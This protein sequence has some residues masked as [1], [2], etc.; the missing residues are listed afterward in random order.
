M[1]CF[2]VGILQGQVMELEIL[3]EWKK[4]EASEKWAVQ[5]LDFI[6]SGLAL[7]R[8]DGTW[9]ESEN[10]AA[11]FSLEKKRLKAQADGVPN[12]RYTGVRFDVGLPVAVNEG[13]VNLLPP[14]HD[15][16][17]DVCG[18]HWGWQG[19]YVFLAIEGRWG[20]GGPKKGG[21]AYHLARTPNVV[22]VELP[23]EFQGGG[24][25][26]LQLG[27]NMAQILRGLDAVVHGTSTHSREGDELVPLLKA[28]IAEAFSLRSVRYDTYQPMTKLEKGR[29]LELIPGTTPYPVAI[30]KR[31]PQVEFP[32]D[33]PLTEEGVAL[34]EKLFHDTRL[35]INN[36]QSCASCHDR[37]FAFS[38]PR[39]LSLGAEGQAGK[40]H[41]M[42]LFNLAWEKVFFWDGRAGSLREQVLMPIQ[43][44]HEMNETLER[45]VDKIADLKG[46]FAVAFET[47][48]ITPERMAKSLEQYLLSL[49]SQESRF[50]KAAR[51][52][53]EMTEEEKQGLQLFV[54]EFDPARGLRGA[55]CFHCHGGT[56]F[57]DHQFKNNG[58]DLNP[59]DLGR[60]L[61]TG[62]PADKG[63]F[64]TPSL[65]NIAVTAP[66]M[67]DG[68]FASLEEVVE[69]YSQGVK[70][71]DTLDPNLA[72]HPETGLQL[73][74][75]EKRAL[76]AFLKTLT[77][78]EFISAPANNKL[79]HRP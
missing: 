45:A 37:S 36:R 75:A 57:T 2:Y 35:S 55:D 17:P 25:M 20:E 4:A 72:K 22:R 32:A 50:D 64:K 31:L 60:M 78:E 33:N 41:S 56:L 14:D 43:D 24:P 71:S 7:K 34:G 27:L 1:L 53:G 15:L 61:V 48:E 76:V 29:G 51:K 18:L 79:A 70:R 63:K 73:T 13:D 42:P 49:I 16:H 59:T 23:G 9:L 38:D 6:L 12:G 44:K 5:R 3:P 62:D 77:D 54:T 40:R 58:L 19:G 74:E 67:H 21:F 65:R 28:N 52:V 47:A 68:R 30:T 11:S 66:Y 8:A 39:I 46:D 10:W 26:T 69:H